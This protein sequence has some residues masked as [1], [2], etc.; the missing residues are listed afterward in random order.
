MDFS[1][2]LNHYHARTDDTPQDFLDYVGNLPSQAV[3]L[4][5]LRELHLGRVLDYPSLDLRLL[6]PRLL[7]HNL[8]VVEM[9]IGSA[10]CFDSI[11]PRLW[12][13]LTKVDIGTPPTPQNSSDEFS[14]TLSDVLR[15]ALRLS[16]L[17]WDTERR[18]DS[19][20]L[21]HI[22][23][24]PTLQSLEVIGCMDAT[25]LYLANT[26][27]SSPKFASLNCLALTPSSATSSVDFLNSIS[28][29]DIHQLHMNHGYQSRGILPFMEAL[30]GH[31]SCNSFS[32]L[33]ITGVCLSEGDSL[34]TTRSFTPLTKLPNLR[35]LR[36]LIKA[37]Y[38]LNDAE[39]EMLAKHWSKLEVLDI[40]SET[41]WSS[42]SQITLKGLESLVYYCRELRTLGIVVD[43]ES[44]LPLPD[45]FV[46]TLPNKHIRILSLGNSKITENC[47]SMSSVADLI[48]LLFPN[49]EQINA[50]HLKP[51]LLHTDREF[52]KRQGEIWSEIGEGVRARRIS[53]SA[54]GSLSS[55]I[56]KESNEGFVKSH[57][58]DFSSLNFNL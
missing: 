8:S 3:I 51:S 48:A 17:R 14:E 16:H 53:N 52:A 36:F 30:P 12:S 18:M 28:S 54:W 31:P 39:V 24:L 56:N 1:V 25:S 37:T 27:K 7:T 44:N 32:S 26:S 34:F 46:R 9:V 33:R 19:D 29:T 23:M 15:A 49:L 57:S 11:T 20:T 2:A 6:L 5:C 47:E 45:D 35:S 38:V 41:G 55:C 42:K 21:L 43:V 22:A 58:H 4:P 50:W 13:F 40:A 10:S